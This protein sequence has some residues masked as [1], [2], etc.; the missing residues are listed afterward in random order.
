MQF[1]HLYAEAVMESVRRSTVQV[2]AP[3]TEIV[4]HNW[5]DLMWARGA[6]AFALDRVADMALRGAD[7]SVA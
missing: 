1:D 5:G 3:P 7:E 2:D 6:A 4:V